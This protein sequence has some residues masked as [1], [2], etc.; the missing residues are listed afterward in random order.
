MTPAL[1]PQAAGFDPTHL[2]QT[3]QAGIWRYLRALGCE[4]SSQSTRQTRSRRG[5]Q[6]QSWRQLSVAGSLASVLVH[7]S[8][9]HAM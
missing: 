2:I 9:S 7:N 3:Y 8:S 4:S 6:R 5:R 1:V